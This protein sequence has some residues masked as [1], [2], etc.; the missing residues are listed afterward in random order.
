[1]KKSILLLGITVTF[2]FGGCSLKAS[3]IKNTDHESLH[4]AIVQ[5]RGLRLLVETTGQVMPNREVE[6]KCKASGEIIKLTVDVSDRVSIGDLLLQLD[7]E[8]EERLVQQ[9]EVNLAI[10]KARLRKAQFEL[11]IAI[12]G[13]KNETKRARSALKSIQVKTVEAKAVSYTHLTLPTKA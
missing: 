7:P 9:N 3:G 13:L 10:S 8:K 1:M 4:D 5:K 12:E 6:I 11:N 2:Y